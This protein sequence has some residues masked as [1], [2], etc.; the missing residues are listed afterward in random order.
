MTNNRQHY[1]MRL[2]CILT[3]KNNMK[4]NRTKSQRS[5]AFK[6]SYYNTS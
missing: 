3:V 5:T 4:N 6:V 2:L 1:I